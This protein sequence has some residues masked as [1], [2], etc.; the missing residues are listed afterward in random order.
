V[1]SNKDVSTCIF[2]A[3]KVSQVESNI[4]AL[5][6][7]EKWTEELEEKVNKI[8]NNDPPQ[9]TNWKKFTPFGSR[10][11]ERVTYNFKAGGVDWE[12]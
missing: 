7:A 3:S 5:Q 11:I 12:R 10:R 8:L 4:K 2:G 6:I 9:E 1:L